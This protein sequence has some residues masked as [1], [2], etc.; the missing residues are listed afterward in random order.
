MKEMRVVKDAG[1]FPSSSFNRPLVVNI[2]RVQKYW[3]DQM[4]GWKN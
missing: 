2:L 4:R 3:R 1:S